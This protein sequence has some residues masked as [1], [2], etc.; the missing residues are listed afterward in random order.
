MKDIKAHPEQSLE[1]SPAP[2]KRW[3]NWYE[4][5]LDHER[6]DGSRFRKGDLFPGVKIWPTKEVAEASHERL[7]QAQ[8]DAN[9]V[10]YSCSI[11]HTKWLG[12]FPDDQ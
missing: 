8:K 4:A 11:G 1:R 12:A 2:S 5:L 10:P 3:R 9:G 7:M 6:I